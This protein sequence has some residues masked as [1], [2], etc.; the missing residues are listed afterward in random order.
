[1]PISR[2]TNFTFAYLTTS[3]NLKKLITVD[4]N[5]LLNSTSSCHI[6]KESSH[7]C[8]HKELRRKSSF[9]A[10]FQDGLRPQGTNFFENFFSKCVQ[11][12]W[13][14]RP[15]KSFENF[16][17]KILAVESSKVERDR[18]FPRRISPIFQLFFQNFFTPTQSLNPSLVTGKQFRS[19]R[20]KL[21]ALQTTLPP[22]VS[23]IL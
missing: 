17:C 6:S 4:V 21:K 18:H 15:A 14:Q 1:M 9:L 5:F 23:Q 12:G 3:V 11:E 8:G 20:Y 16:F 7:S 2:F 13:F 19:R 10:I 22:G